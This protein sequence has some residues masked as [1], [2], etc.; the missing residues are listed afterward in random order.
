MLDMLQ[1][2]IIFTLKQV[3]HNVFKRVGNNL[4]TNLNITLQES[5]LGFRR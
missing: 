4:Y 2:D 5:L 1:S 3:E